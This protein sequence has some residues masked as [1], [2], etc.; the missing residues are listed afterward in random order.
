MT[1]FALWILTLISIVSTL[2]ESDSSNTNIT[3][4][5]PVSNR[6]ITRNDIHSRFSDTENKTN[7]EA[8]GNK[9]ET[10]MNKTE[11]NKTELKKNLPTQT[12]KIESSFVASN[13]TEV[14]NKTKEA[15][16]LLKDFKP[17][18]HLGSFFDDENAEMNDKFRMMKLT[19]NPKSLILLHSPHKEVYYQHPSY[20]NIPKEI[21]YTHEE[22]PYKFE[23]TI[24]TKT[25]QGWQDSLDSKPTVEVP[26]KVPAGGLYKSPEAF[27]DKPQSV[28]EYGLEYHEDEKEHAMKK[29][30]NPW[31]NLL[32]LV[33]AFIPVG[34]IISALT[35]S[36]ITIH[37]VDD[38]LK[39]TSL[40]YRRSDIDAGVTNMAPISER[41]RR[42][43]LC[44]LHSEKN[45]V[46][47]RTLPR[48]TMKQCYKIHCED[49]EALWKMLR[50]LFTYNQ[51]TGD[52]RGRLIT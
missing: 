11:S 41:C 40:P 7:K 50:W 49:T 30:V 37:N 23:D 31:Q 1:V 10:P 24:Y 12:W 46:P 32:R 22:F 20:N 33:T 39:P 9:T 47:P 21:Y 52:Q 15:K 18:Q 5:Y 42:R 36:V 4:L 35:P 34:L 26:V 17:S 2:A 44:E 29:R 28:E 51:E 43:L 19:L 45:Y 48:R 38:N 6:N 14:N 16:E 3:T 27:K 8:I 25:K 13:L